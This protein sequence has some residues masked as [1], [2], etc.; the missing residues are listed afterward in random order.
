LYG[1]DDNDYFLVMRAM[2]YE[3]QATALMR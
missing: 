3:R 2:I 1:G